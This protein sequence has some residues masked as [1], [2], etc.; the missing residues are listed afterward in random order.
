MGKVIS[1]FV[2]KKGKESIGQ[3][4]KSAWNMSYKDIDGNLV[5]FATFQGNYLAYLIVNVASN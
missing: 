5:D 1:H 2:F 3:V 4:P